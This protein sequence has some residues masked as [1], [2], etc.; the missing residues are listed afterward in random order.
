MVNFTIDY[1]DLSSIIILIDI[2]G[3]NM[4]FNKEI[5]EQIFAVDINHSTI[6]NILNEYM[7]FLERNNEKEYAVFN[8]LIETDPDFF[9]KSLK[10][11]YTSVVVGN[12]IL[13]FDANVDF[14]N[15]KE[16]VM[17]T[18]SFIYDDEM[19]YPMASEIIERAVYSNKSLSSYTEL[20]KI[21]LE[22]RVSDFLSR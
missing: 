18:F 6:V 17:N 8:K 7:S 2:V 22:N 13:T 16:E 3:I 1:K 15:F 14:S 19:L 4:V 5:V 20:S 11:V 12:C 21:D 10:A 9:D